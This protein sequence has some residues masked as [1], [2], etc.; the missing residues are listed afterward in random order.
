[1]SRSLV[2]CDRRPII[3]QRSSK[4]A[5]Q[6]TAPLA[7]SWNLIFSLCSLQQSVD[8]LPQFAPGVALLCGQ[9]IQSGGVAY[10]CEVG[11]HLPAP[12][13]FL[14]R[15]KMLCPHVEVGAKPLAGLV[16]PTRTLLAVE[17]V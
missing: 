12:Q 14:G 5:V 6:L 11:V 17:F 16:S 7:A 13:L 10:P 8:L 1:M 3:R 9:F 2:F 4:G 15:L